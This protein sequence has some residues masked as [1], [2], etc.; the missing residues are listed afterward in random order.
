ME[1][2][3]YHVNFEKRDAGYTTGPQTPNNHQDDGKAQKCSKYKV[4]S[5]AVMVVIMFEEFGNVAYNFHNC[6]LRMRTLNVY[7]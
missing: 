2:D 1:L 5:K 3:I 4:Y 6:S 7:I